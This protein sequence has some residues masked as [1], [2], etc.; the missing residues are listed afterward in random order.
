MPRTKDLSASADNSFGRLGGPLMGGA[1]RSGRIAK[2]IHIL[3]FGTDTS[4]HIFSEETSTVV[5]SRHGAGIVSR[6][7]VAADEVLT[8]RLSGTSA[9][10]GVRLVGQM[11]QETRGYTYGV[12]FLDSDLDF[13]ELKFPAPPQW[14]SDPDAALECSLCHDR[15]VVHQS[16]IEADVYALLQSILRFCPRCGTSTVWRE[17]PGDG[18][19][20]AEELE[21]PLPSSAHPALV[22]PADPAPAQFALA[23]SLIS[24]SY[25]SEPV[26]SESVLTLT[27]KE[28]SVPQASQETA[29]PGRIPPLVPPASVQRTGNRRRALRS[30]VNF[31]ALVRHADLGEE[32]AES[33]NISKGGFSFRSLRAYPVNSMIEVAV[34][35]SPGFEAIFVPACIRHVEELPGGMLFRYGAAYTRPP[36]SPRESAPPEPGP[37]AA[38]TS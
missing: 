21:L 38:A 34:P 8:L 31:T 22:N 1:R 30:R 37:A 16:E 26:S 7:K 9:E 27:E 25:S 4:G 5:L 20:P 6:H 18:F 17:A 3:L 28:H 29:R 33:D 11:G 15:Q 19:A 36:K 10:A 32:I 2:E 14:H 23:G 35:Y 13:W 12:E 24:T